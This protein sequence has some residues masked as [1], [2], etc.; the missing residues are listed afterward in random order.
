MLGLKWAMDFWLLIFLCKLVPS[1]PPWHYKKIGNIV[2]LFLFLF[3]F[4]S[5]I[6]ATIEG[7]FSCVFSASTDIHLGSTFSYFT[8]PFPPLFSVFSSAIYC[9]H[10]QRSGSWEGPEFTLQFTRT[11]QGMPFSCYGLGFMQKSSECPGQVGAWQAPAG[12]SGC[13]IAGQDSGMLCKI[14]LLQGS[15]AG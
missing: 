7:H 14:N 1:V 15:Y 13:R 11:Y 3:L 2:I 4:I 5:N 12:P 10:L 6:S 8:F 9:L